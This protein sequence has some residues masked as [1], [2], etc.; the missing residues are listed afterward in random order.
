MVKPTR[1]SISKALQ[2]D[3]YAVNTAMLDL[4]VAEQNVSE[5][6]ARLGKHLRGMRAVQG[7]SLR[8]LAGKLGL[9]ASYVSDVELGRRNINPML[10]KWLSERCV[11]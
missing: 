11:R 1:H 10:M 7:I 2:A 9:S 6:K 8:A 5:V 4:T 3:L